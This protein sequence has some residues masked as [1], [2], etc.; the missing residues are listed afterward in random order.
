M[1]SP[2][3]ISPNREKG[4]STSTVTTSKRH[5]KPVSKFDDFVVENPVRNLISEMK[6]VGQQDEMRYPLK[7]N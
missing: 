6:R 7:Y 4:E 2:L 1:S 3:E 5:R